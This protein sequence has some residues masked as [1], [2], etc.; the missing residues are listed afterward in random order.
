MTTQLSEVPGYRPGRNWIRVGDTCYCR[1]TSGGGFE[2]R[3]RRILADD[4]G[5]VKEIEV[6]GGRRGRAAIRTFRPEQ[7]R[8]LAQS[9]VEAR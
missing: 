2:A 3:I 9:R 4:A 6:F 8:R 7:I 5:D 1:P